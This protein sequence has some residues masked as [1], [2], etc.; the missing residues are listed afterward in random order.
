MTHNC[1]RWPEASAPA[2]TS[3][4]SVPRVEA[5][6]LGTGVGQVAV[7]GL[8]GNAEDPVLGRVDRGRELDPGAA[9]VVGME[10][11]RRD[12][13]RRLRRVARADELQL[14]VIARPL[15]TTNEHLA[16]DD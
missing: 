4:P 10:R 8:G 13:V 16:P 5:Q 7:T 14:V 2:P 12:P 6:D 11:S 9:A 15:E 3:A 1:R